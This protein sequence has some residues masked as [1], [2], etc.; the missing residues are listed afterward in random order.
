[1]HR[2]LR[3]ATLGL[4]LVVAGTPVALAS[5]AIVTVGPASDP[6]CQ[7]QSLQAGLDALAQSGAVTRILRIARPSPDS[8]LYPLVHL[9]I[10]TQMQIV[11]GF[12]SCSAS[13]P[14]P[15]V[16]TILEGAP[17]LGSVVTVEITGATRRS[18]LLENVSLQRGDAE[19]GGG[20][21]I[22]G[23][24]DVHLVSALILNNEAAEGG[25]IFIDGA[26]GAVLMMS[27]NTAVNG[28]RANRGDGIGGG[29]SCAGG[30]TIV[31]TSGGMFGNEASGIR[32]NG[33]GLALRGCSALISPPYSINNNRAVRGAGIYAEEGSPLAV[34]GGGGS[35]RLADNV[36]DGPGS[37]VGRGGGIYLS[38]PGTA[39]QA[40]ALK[41]VRNRSLDGSGGGIYV[42]NG[43]LL[44]LSRGPV[45][46]AC[47]QPGACS[48]L[49][50]NQAANG[51]AA[52][53]RDARLILGE[54]D[55]RGNLAAADGAVIFAGATQ[56]GV[57]SLVVNGTTF[58][59]NLG[60]E[61]IGVNGPSLLR[62]HHVTAAGNHGFAQVVR[63]LGTTP[64]G[65]SIEVRNSIL[66]EPLAGGQIN[67]INGGPI[68]GG[69]L[70]VAERTGLP[71][72]MFAF[73]LNPRL[74]DESAGDLR[75]TLASP[76]IDLC[77]GVD[78]TP[79]DQDG[80][81][82]GFDIPGVPDHSPGSF[83]DAGADELV[84]D[85]GI[86]SDGF[87]SGGLGSWSSAQP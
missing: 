74:V 58:T 68:T 17:G 31:A 6:S 64:G 76:A 50:D 85:H 22:A 62:M 5:T 55:V 39:M 41:L 72:D 35:V 45:A 21:S 4:A 80:E 24:A 27:Q 38:G 66:Y 83:F 2:T 30:G 15:G 37:A 3:F 78:G 69:C 40:T 75:L 49:L 81:L 29:L 82:R 34:T 60:R 86:F 26:Q 18:V 77:P 11:G 87:E 10:T 61:A 46:G 54:V 20:L 13:A 65:P 57:T 48:Q 8:T 19:Q 14:T 25:G 53:V 47:A 23:K 71:L 51:A 36:V 70:V 67:N 12:E 7:F 44:G 28:N 33:G 16:R 63:G 56:P 43:A 1:M 42:E 79:R 84:I 52:E 32:G 9:Q 73:E 59:L